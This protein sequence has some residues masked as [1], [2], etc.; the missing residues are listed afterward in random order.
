MAE[1]PDELKKLVAVATDIVLDV[2]LRSNAVKLIGEMGS[3]EA[4]LALLSLVAN[5]KLTRG[6]RELALNES[7]RIVRSGH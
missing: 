1:K 5:E 6:E 2:K 3:Y 7:R 4:L